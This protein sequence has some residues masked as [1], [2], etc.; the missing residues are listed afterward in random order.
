LQS[1][2]GDHSNPRRETIIMNDKINQKS[3]RFL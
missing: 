1:P 2:G 3:G